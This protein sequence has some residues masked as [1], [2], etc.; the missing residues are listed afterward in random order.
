MAWEF[1]TDPEYQ[2]QLDWAA[3]FV[4]EEVAPLDA[5]WRGL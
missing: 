5:L 2:Q 4:R 3:T 1:E